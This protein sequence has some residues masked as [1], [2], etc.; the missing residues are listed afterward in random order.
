M[1]LYSDSQLLF[2]KGL[3]T[4]STEPALARAIELITELTGGKVA[5]SVMTEQANPYEPRVFS[6]DPQKARTLMGIE[7][8]ELGVI[9]IGAGLGATYATIAGV[10]T[11]LFLDNWR[12]VPWATCGGAIAGA[13][14]GYRAISD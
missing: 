11:S 3:S 1:N 13:T 6:F 10:I 12:L 7:M 2:E 9:L 5:S 14:A 4:E 8:D